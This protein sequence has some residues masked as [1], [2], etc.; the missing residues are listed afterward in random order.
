M[1]TGST[2]CRFF[3]ND[4]IKVHPFSPTYGKIIIVF[5]ILLFSPSVVAMYGVGGTASLL[6]SFLGSLIS[7]VINQCGYGLNLSNTFLKQLSLDSRMLII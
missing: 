7:L 6:K 1:L 2:F 3:F 4:L 5:L